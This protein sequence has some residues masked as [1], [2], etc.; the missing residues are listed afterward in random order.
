MVLHGRNY[1]FIYTDA[2]YG[3]YVYATLEIVWGEK[4]NVLF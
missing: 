1:R 3:M 2:F 4:F